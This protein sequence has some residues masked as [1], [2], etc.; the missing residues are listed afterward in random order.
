MQFSKTHLPDEFSFRLQNNCLGRS[1]ECRFSR[2]M[3]PDSIEMRLLLKE[4]EQSP[5]QN[6][7]LGDRR[8]GV[9]LIAAAGIETK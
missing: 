4:I 2:P 8:E 3:E 6:F 1:R 7:G 9:S 5:P